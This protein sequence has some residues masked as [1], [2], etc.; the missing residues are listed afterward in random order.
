MADTVLER[1]LVQVGLDADLASLREVERLLK[2]I[3]SSGGSRAAT[4]LAKPGEAQKASDKAAKEATR[5]FIMRAR[6]E[7]K[8]RRDADRVAAQAAKAAER[9]SQARERE[10]RREAAARSRYE[11]RITD[12]RFK[13]NDKEFR[14]ATAEGDKRERQ[15]AAAAIRVAKIKERLREK[16]SREHKVEE[17]R[18]ARAAKKYIEIVRDGYVG[19]MALAA[20]A[21]AM[22]A[23]MVSTSS[24]EIEDNRRLGLGLGL[25]TQGAFEM[26]HVFQS[27]GADVNDVS[28]A[29]QTLSDY[30]LEAL[31]GNEEWVKTFKAANVQIGDLRDKRPDE[32]LEV[33]ADSISGLANAED[34]AA[35][36]AR[37]FGDDVGRKL[38]PLLTMGGDAVR[39]L[40]EE[41]REFAGI[42]TEEAAEANGQ[43]VISMRRVWLGMKGLQTLFVTTMAPNL[44]EMANNFLLL[45]KAIVP[46]TKSET[47]K[48]AGRLGESLQFLSSPLGRTLATTAGLVAFGAALKAIYGTAKQLP[49]VGTMLTQI[50]AAAAVIAKPVAILTLLYLV[51]EDLYYASQGYNSVS[52]EMAKQLGVD[53]ELQIA[54]FGL[55]ELFKS[56]AFFTW[57]FANAMTVGIGNALIMASKL[58]PFLEPFIKLL[59]S[60]VF[61]ASGMALGYGL[62]VATNQ[63]GAGE[64][65][66]TGVKGGLRLVGMG[67]LSAGAALD[68]GGYFLRTATSDRA[69]WKRQGGGFAPMMRRIGMAGQAAVETAPGAIQNFSINVTVPAGYQS[70]HELAGAIAVQVKGQTG[71]APK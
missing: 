53:E 70:P 71:M 24:T 2:S 56:A 45:W 9:A 6:A 60:G 12:Q 8:A 50:G 37:I 69:G 36:A 3:K 25:G 16:E 10:W 7:V 57:E 31:A 41:Y 39:E 19:L 47:W 32:L 11:Q 52:G 34:R 49:I 22:L 44:R 18:R 55:V 59:D 1:F 46:Y 30:S 20:G 5:Q 26:Q 21:G 4:K 67:G 43:F 33:L 63:G 40:R 65:L 42:V 23:R 66:Q 64:E 68:E 29:L 61:G 17:A 38:L 14:K 13:I 35:A 15:Q 54:L 62:K 28:D 48:W 58:R 51:L 27:M